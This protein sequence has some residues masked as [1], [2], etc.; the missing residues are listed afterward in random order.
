MLVA[1][2]DNPYY[3]IATEIKGH[4]FRYSKI[5][6]WQGRDEDLV[7]TMQRGVGFVNGRDGLVFENVLALYTHVHAIG[8]PQWAANLVAQALAH[9]KRQE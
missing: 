3:P 5:L 1:D 9:K 2:R 8:T 6:S 7:L 4:E